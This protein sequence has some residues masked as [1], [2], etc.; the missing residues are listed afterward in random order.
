MQKSAALKINAQYHLQCCVIPLVE[1]ELG[2][3]EPARRE[4]QASHLYGQMQL[5]GLCPN[6]FYSFFFFRP[7]CTKCIKR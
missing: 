6:P 3:T 4:K 2:W 1:V 7:P 5:D